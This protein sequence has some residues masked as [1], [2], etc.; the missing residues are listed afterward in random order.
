MPIPDEIT[1]KLVYAAV[2]FLAIKD[3][4]HAINGYAMRIPYDMPGSGDTKDH[5]QRHLDHVDKT[6]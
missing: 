2:Q 6:L 5:L 3:F 4:I 1:V